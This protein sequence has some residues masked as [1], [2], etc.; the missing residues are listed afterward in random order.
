LQKKSLICSNFL[1]GDYELIKIAKIAIIDSKEVGL[2]V[3]AK[4]PD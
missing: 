3:R 1:K 4:I 2:M